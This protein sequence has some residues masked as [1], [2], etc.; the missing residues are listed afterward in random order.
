MRCA[1]TEPGP[2]MQTFYDSKTIL[3]SQKS[4]E[5]TTIYNCFKL[6]AVKK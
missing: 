4:L 1:F 2:Q 6:L 3:D 5:N